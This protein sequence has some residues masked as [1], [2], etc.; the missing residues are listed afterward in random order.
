MLT[1]TRDF[2][3]IGTIMAAFAAIAAAPYVVVIAHAAQVIGGA[4]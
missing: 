3:I 2:A 4:S 1:R